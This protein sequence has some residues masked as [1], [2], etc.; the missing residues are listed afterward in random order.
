MTLPKMKIMLTD[1]VGNIHSVDVDQEMEVSKFDD[2]VSE[3]ES[4]N[5]S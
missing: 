1:E 3:F 4:F 5:R 2:Q